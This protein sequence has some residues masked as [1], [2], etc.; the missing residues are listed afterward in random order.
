MCGIAGILHFEPGRR[1]QK[2]ILKKMTDII[3]H[4]G[5]DGEGFFV[6]GNIGLGHRRLSII[7][8]DT[9]DQPMLNDDG[10]IV[11]VFNGEIYNYIEL[12]NELKKLG[13]EFT[14]L[15]DTEV[16]IRAYEQWGY[17]CQNKFNGMWAFAL[18]DARKQELF[19]SRDRIGEKPLHYTE[20][21]N[22][23]IFASEI[24][25]LFKYGIPKIPRLE[26][27]E[28]Y[29]NLTNIPAPH[30][31]YSN[32][33][34]L[35]PGHYLIIQGSQISEQK[36]WELPRI[37]EQNMLRDKRAIY[38]EFEELFINSIKIRMRSDVPYGAFLSGGLDSSAI[39][40][41]MAGI[42]SH[43]VQTFTIGFDEKSFDESSLAQDVA[44]SFRT[45]HTRGTVSPDDFNDVLRKVVFHY[46]EPFGDSSAIPMGHVAR[47]AS[48][49]V[50]MVLTGDGGDEVLSGYPAYQ[51]LK[52]A[53]LYNKLPGII[54]RGLPTL[55]SLAVN[56][57]NGDIRYKLNRIVN[58]LYTSNLSFQ[59]RYL[60]KNTKVGLKTIKKLVHSIDDIIPI[61]DYM[62]DVLASIPAKDD[63]YKLMYFHFMHN[64]PND[65]LVKVDRMSMAYSLETRVPFLDHR[66]IEFMFQVD[67][68]IKMQGWERKSILRGT[69]GKLLPKSILQASKKGFSIPV[70]EWFKREDFFLGN[71]LKNAKE[72]LNPVV[73]DN[74]VREN[75]QGNND[76]GNFIWQL[77]V[78]NEILEA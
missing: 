45:N 47:L 10:S 29:L 68:N 62:S 24:K 75:Q 22:S 34:K 31:F 63:F 52:F 4:R 30:T 51:G 36:Y 54:A 9:G 66:L 49:K 46:D 1:V 60:E 19:L 12:R 20:Y 32:I 15:S 42:S 35:K 2:S 38:E 3:S 44:D 64:L 28:V 43:P 65:F 16:I 7:D 78:L 56:N 14:T 23:F 5:P 69:V 67:K 61:E 76:N 6:K 55:L 53:G 70:R 58:V 33:K 11:L 73:I 50:K 48:E 74:I 39:V 40:A 57:L 41:L 21:K 18:W 71:S 26:M 77:F 59:N 37:D 17:D 27:L 13:H 72:I 8:L 25:S